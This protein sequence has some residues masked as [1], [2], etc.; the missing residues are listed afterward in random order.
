MPVNQTSILAVIERF[1]EHKDRIK[2][3]YREIEAFQ[4]LCSDYRKCVEA[5]QH[6]NESDSKEA[7]AL[8][9][10]YAD[11]LEELELEI[12]QYMNEHS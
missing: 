8:R 6:W 3:L 2:L 4:T 5:H 11:L 7:S 10:E 12:M 1:P 9:K